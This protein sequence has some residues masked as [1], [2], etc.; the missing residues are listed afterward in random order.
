[1]NTI[2]GQ[3]DYLPTDW[4][5][6]WQWSVSL[7]LW[8]RSRHRLPSAADKHNMTESLPSVG[9]LVGLSVQWLIKQNWLAGFAGEQ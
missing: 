4:Q 2:V 6:R 7:S 5:E 1:M 9:G 8:G 3:W